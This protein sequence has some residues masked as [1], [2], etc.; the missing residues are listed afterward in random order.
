MLFLIGVLALV[1]G[2]DSDA[3][4]QRRGADGVWLSVGWPVAPSIQALDGQEVLVE[5][6]FD[7]TKQGHEAAYVGSLADIR[8]IAGIDISVHQ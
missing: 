1:F 7:S 8:K 6:T 5:G 2:C 4:R 3:Y